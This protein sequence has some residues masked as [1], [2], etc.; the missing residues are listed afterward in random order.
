MAGKQL[1]DLE[2]LFK[3]LADRTRL[4]ILGL[5]A[6]GEI[7]VCEIHETLR[8]PQPKASRHLAYLRAAGLVDARRKGLWVY[9]RLAQP[10]DRVLSVVHQAARHALQHV[11]DVERDV[12]RFQKKTGCCATTNV[13]KPTFACCPEDAAPSAELRS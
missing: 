5:L 6:S 12:A 8:I 13:E 4:R 1:T 9:Y 11:G 3:A 2:A 10:A 7:C